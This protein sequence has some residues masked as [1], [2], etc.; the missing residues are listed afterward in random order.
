MNGVV[1]DHTEHEVDAVMELAG[2]P[3]WWTITTE[4]GDCEVVRAVF[5]L[6]KDFPDFPEELKEHEMY[7][8]MGGEALI[9]IVL[10]V[11]LFKWPP[12]A[13]PALKLGKEGMASIESEGGAVVFYP[14]PMAVHFETLLCDVNL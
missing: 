10:P 4:D 13:A 12:L 1:Q 5:N 11:G 2:R 8:K 7:K 14:H 6:E 3:R 9:Y